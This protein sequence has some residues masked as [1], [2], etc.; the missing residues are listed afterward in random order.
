MQTGTSVAIG[1]T[2][3]R[4]FGAATS[5]ASW[6][7]KDCAFAVSHFNAT[8][9]GTIAGVMLDSLGINS[10]KAACKSGTP[11]TKPDWIQNVVR[12]GLVDPVVAANPTLTIFGNGLVGPSAFY[13]ANNSTSISSDG[14]CDHVSV[15]IAESWI[16][17]N[18]DKW[19][20]WPVNDTTQNTPGCWQNAVQMLIDADLLHNCG[21]WS[22]VNIGNQVPAGGVPSGWVPY[23]TAQ[24][25]QWKRFSYCSHMLGQRG[26]SLYEFVTASTTKPWNETHPYWTQSLGAP[27]TSSSTVAAMHDSSGAYIRH[28]ASGT[29]Y[30]NPTSAA[31]NLVA[32]QAYTN[33]DTGVSIPNAGQ[34]HLNA[35]DGLLLLADASSPS[36]TDTPAITITAPTAAQVFA[37]G[38][39]ILL[40]TTVTDND[41]IATVTA[42][43]DGGAALPC[44]SLPSNVYQRT[45]GVL[46]PGAH[47]ITVTA[48]DAFPSTPLSSQ[49]SVSF[50]VSAPPP[51]NTPPVVTVTGPADVVVLPATAVA[52]CDASD[53]DGISGVTVSLDNGTAVAMS[54]A[55][56]ATPGGAFTLDLGALAEGSHRVDFRATDANASPLATTASKSFLVSSNSGGGGGGGGT[57]GGGTGGGGGGTVVG[58]PPITISTDIADIEVRIKD[59][60]L[61]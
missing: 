39:T 13:A 29:V 40:T 59:R 5:Y 53:V 42:S 1:Y 60:G 21:V 8:Y 15:A 36:D 3:A 9:T 22:I 30:V 16:R 61:G 57:G 23:T 10:Y 2:D 41:G 17:N 24:V 32:D 12:V 34:I 28:Y 35:N 33:P 49:K 38:S 4:G 27:T 47:S 19:G 6:K 7:S 43:L 46:A 14:L 44:A 48:L 31:I 56:R 11:Y 18:Y 37:S 25:D 45:I 54:P 52:S 26:R 50:T 51:V 20:T 58:A 55:S